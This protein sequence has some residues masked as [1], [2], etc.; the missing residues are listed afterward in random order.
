[1]V[2]FLRV[3]QEEELSGLDISEHGMQAYVAD[4]M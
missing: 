3:S 4:S 2:G 1:M